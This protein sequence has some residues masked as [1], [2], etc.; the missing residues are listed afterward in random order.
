MNERLLLFPAVDREPPADERFI[1]RVVT[2]LLEDRRRRRRTRLL[3]AAA[4]LFFF[5]AGAGQIAF[6][7]ASAPTPDETYS[8][9]ITPSPLEGLLPE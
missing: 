7:G 2:A 9:L 1:H 4:L 6:A 3:A 5:F 8:G